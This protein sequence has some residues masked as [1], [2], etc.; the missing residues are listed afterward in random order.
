[1]I[2][3]PEMFCYANSKSEDY[4]DEQADPNLHWV[5]CPKLGS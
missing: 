2:R 5:T 4:E 3:S 1:M